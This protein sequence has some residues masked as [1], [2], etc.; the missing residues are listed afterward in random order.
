MIQI[1]VSEITRDAGIVEPAWVDGDNSNGNYWT[2]NDGTIWLEIQSTSG[3]PQTVE[4]AANPALL[5]D[6]LPVLPLVINVPANTTVRHGCFRTNTFNQNVDG[7]VY[8]MPSVSTTLKFRAF[9]ADL[10]RG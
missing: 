2:G 8:V 3:S 9:K 4:I 10:A 7:D 5:T 6:G 1:P